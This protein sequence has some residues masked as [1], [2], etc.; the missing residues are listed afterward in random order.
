MTDKQTGARAAAEEIYYF[1]VNR[2]VG[3]ENR[4]WS[5]DNIEA[6]ILKHCPQDKAVELVE[7][8]KKIKDRQF[9]QMLCPTAPSLDASEGFKQGAQQATMECVEIAHAALAEYEEA[10]K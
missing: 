8:L 9:V 2:M 3:V 6:I 10:T 5:K 4:T 1:A 7:A